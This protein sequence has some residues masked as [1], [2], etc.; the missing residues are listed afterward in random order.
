MK[1][2]F[3]SIDHPSCMYGAGGLLVHS[4]PSYLAHVSPVDS[5]LSSIVG[6]LHEYTKLTQVNANCSH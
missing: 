3:L 2:G 5:L 4:G 6:V 1:N